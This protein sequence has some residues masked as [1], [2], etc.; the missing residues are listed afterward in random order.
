MDV[1]GKLFERGECSLK[2]RIMMKKLCVQLTSNFELESTKETTKKI[3]KS[4]L[5]TKLKQRWKFG[6]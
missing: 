4:M 5:E 2:E 3:V 6:K 1:R